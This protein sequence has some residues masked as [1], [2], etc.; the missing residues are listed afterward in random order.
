MYF[1]TVKQ[2]HLSFMDIYRKPTAKQKA[3]LMQLLNAARNFNLAL[4]LYSKT[5]MLNAGV[6]GESMNAAGNVYT[7]Q[8]KINQI[9]KS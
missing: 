3:M 7:L 8:K 9:L 5:D 2:N 1:R 4:N 6:F